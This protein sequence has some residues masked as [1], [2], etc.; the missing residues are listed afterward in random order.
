MLSKANAQKG[1]STPNEL[2]K[3]AAANMKTNNME[4]FRPLY[5]LQKNQTEKDL[6]AMIGV[7]KLYPRLKMFLE[8]GRKKFGKDFNYEVIDRFNYELDASMNWVVDFEKTSTETFK[9]SKMAED[10]IIATAPTTQVN[11]DGETSN[12]SFVVMQYN[13]K[14][15]FAVPYKR[16]EL[17]KAV[18]PFIDQ[19]EKLLQEST[20]A[21]ELAK[22]MKPLGNLF[23]D[24]YQN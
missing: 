15:F 14:W 18:A 17:L 23:S 4:A 11:P 1:A 13:G 12:M 5:N 19:S 24:Y 16:I 10:Y 2:F 6:D 21:E 20:S 8:N 22:K 7:M 9:V 3:M